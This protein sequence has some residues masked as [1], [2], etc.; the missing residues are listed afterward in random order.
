[1]DYDKTQMPASYDAG[2]GYP[3]SVLAYWLDII[4]RSMD[5]V[6]IAHILDLG[7]G[8]GRYSEPLAARFDAQVI[9]VDPSE[10]MLTAARAKASDR[11]VVFERAEAAAL[12]IASGSIDMVF[13][14]MVFHHLPDAHA[15]L[16]ECR[17]VLRPE[18]VICMRAGTREQLDAYAYAPFFPASRAILERT[19]QSSDEIVTI[20]AQAGFRLSQH[21]AV[22]SQAAASWRDYSDRVAVRADSIL[23]QLSDSIFASGLADLRRFAATRPDTEPVIEPVDYFVFRGSS[24]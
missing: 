12:P 11:R 20:F 6:A 4:A 15:A 16:A 19:L 10:Q 5:G 1:V 17:R 2:R 13:M 8:T 21:T 3:P 23:V 22:S 9:A 14:S 7:C 24:H 18:G